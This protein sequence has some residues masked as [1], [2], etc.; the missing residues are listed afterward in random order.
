MPP[1]ITYRTEDEVRDK[2]KILLG[3]DDIETD[4]KQ[5][6]GQTTTF[7]QLGFKGKRSKPDGWYLPNDHA[8]PAIILET[9]SETQDISLQKWVNELTKNCDIAATQYKQVIGILYNGT[10]LRVFKNNIEVTSIASTLQN[11]TY[12]LALFTQNTIDKQRIYTLTKRIN[13]CL[14]TEFG[15][16]NLYHRMIFTACALVA[17]RYN[18]LLTEGMN[19]SV[20]KHSILTTLADSLSD[21]QRVNLK[22]EL[23]LEVY[24]EIKMNNASNQEA[25]DHFIGWVTEI[26]DCIRSDDWNGEDVMGILFNE[27]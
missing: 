26:S 24:S 22:L 21:D 13:N 5:G 11:K 9:K 7:N 16:K 10:D 25:I 3:F 27:F 4:I 23:L 17:K 19:F 12:Y 6:V 15:I 8:M 14:H 1:K 2:A 18:A 20:M